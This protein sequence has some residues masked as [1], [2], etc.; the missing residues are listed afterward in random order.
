MNYGNNTNSKNNGAKA[1]YVLQTRKLP[2]R[3]QYVLWDVYAGT[4]CSVSH[5][6]RHMGSC[7]KELG[8][9]R[10][11]VWKNSKRAIAEKIL[12]WGWEQ[13]SAHRQEELKSIKMEQNHVL[14]V[15]NNS[16]SAFCAVHLDISYLLTYLLTYLLHGVQSF[17]RS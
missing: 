15:L 10:K 6:L 11:N 1:H 12:V 3:L 8:K 9:K 5:R 14:R 2:D 13:C 16:N 4:E 7:K 17:L